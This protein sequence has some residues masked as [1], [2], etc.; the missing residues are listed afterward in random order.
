M[1]G[2]ELGWL[3]LCA[4]LGD[5][6]APLTLPQLRVLKARM[7][8]ELPPADPDRPVNAGD[9]RRLG[10]D[11]E[12]ADRIT[13]LL[14]REAALNTYLALGAEAGVHPLTRISPGYPIRLEQR[15]GREAPAV[16]FYKGDVSC[17]EGPSAAVVGSRDLTRGGAAFARLAGEKLA[18]SG[19]TLISG[20]ARGADQTA[21][22]ACL[23]AGGRVLCF[24]PGD[25][26]PLPER[27]RVCWICE[28]G[29][30]L[31]F[32]AFRALRRNLFIHAMGDL[33]LAAQTGTAGGTW[34]GCTENLKRGLS[35]L[36]VRRDGSPGADDLI[37]RGAVPVETF[38]DLDQLCPAQ[39]PLCPL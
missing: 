31:P 24:V 22:A 25:L 5:G 15:L 28:Q 11:W 10:Y 20:N 3:L 21:Q 17:L 23:D 34:S 14:D 29:W 32:A 26:G 37:A 33:T 27:E 36:Y 30:H 18:R 13:A 2:P 19:W 7:Q 35:P 16:L 12:T 4:D 1:T 39:L 6:L 38:P 8:S 9:L